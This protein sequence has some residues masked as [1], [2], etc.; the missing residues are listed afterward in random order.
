M[1]RGST[2]TLTANASRD[3]ASASF[4]GTP[5]EPS[6]DSFS[7][8]GFLIDQPQKIVLKW[9]DHH[10]LSGS[11]PFQLS[12]EATDD[13]PPTLICDDL[14]RRKVML[15]TEVLSFT[16]RSRDDFGVK[17]VGL[18]WQGIDESLASMPSGETILGAGNQLAESLELA[19]TFSPET[20][21]IQPQ[22][23][24]VRVFVE[25]YLPGR[26]RVYSP[27]S[28]FDVLMLSNMPSGSQHSSQ[29]GTGCLDVRDREMQLHETNKQLREL[30]PEE[31]A[32]DEN[33]AK[34][35]DQ[36]ARERNNGRR[37]KS[38]VQNGEGLLKEACET[39]T[40]PW[41]ISNNGPR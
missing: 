29:G 4:N 2:T 18:E 21:K 34:L 20:H 41:R 13:A 36:S 1:V 19:G 25:D 32:T 22:P 10:G 30:P 14:P 27:T 24:A 3:L 35:S 5:A 38:L 7:T 33:V 23:I 17:R 31:L 28:V 15:D 9:S 40:L 11:K 16:V 8:T 6:S 12:I 37:L 39:R 26:E